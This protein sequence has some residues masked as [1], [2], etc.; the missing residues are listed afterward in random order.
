MGPSGID[1]TCVWGIGM[2]S[3]PDH[4]MWCTGTVAG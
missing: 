3:G 1:D 4:G 2:A